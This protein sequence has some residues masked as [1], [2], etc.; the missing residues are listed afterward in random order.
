MWLLPSSRND[1][2]L[3]RAFNISYAYQD[4]MHDHATG[5]A[6]GV[7]STDSAGI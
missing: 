5:L 6:A 7:V 4:D 3:L 2:F 1:V